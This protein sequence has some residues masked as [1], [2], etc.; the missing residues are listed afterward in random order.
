MKVSVAARK[1]WGPSPRS[2]CLVPA[3]ES[4][5]TMRVSDGNKSLPQVWGLHPE[6]QELLSI[7][8]AARSRSLQGHVHSGALSRSP[9]EKSFLSR[10]FRAVDD[11][12]YT[13]TRAEILSRWQIQMFL[14]NRQGT[15]KI[16][17]LALLIF[18]SNVASFCATYPL[19]IPAEDISFSLITGVSV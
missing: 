4:C 3:A 8:V 12:F 18:G 2:L 11:Y 5:D 13:K 9:I 16:L 7:L 10:D 17:L 1:S 19:G 14:K 15:P 6:G